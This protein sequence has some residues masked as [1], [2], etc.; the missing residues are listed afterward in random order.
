MKHFRLTLAGN[1]GG[2][3]NGSGGEEK[4]R[5]AFD[6]PGDKWR[7]WSTLL[8]P[9]E[10]AGGWIAQVVDDHGNVLKSGPLH[11]APASPTG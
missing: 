9:E 5:V 4:Y 1:C 10:L 11:C 3:G 7:F 6:V 2:N 8:R